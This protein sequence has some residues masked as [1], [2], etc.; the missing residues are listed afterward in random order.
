[1]ID[2][3]TLGEALVSFRTPGPLVGPWRAEAHVAGAEANVAIG[4]ARLGHRSAWVGCVSD[5]DLGT[6]VT[7]TLAAEGVDT[8][9]VRR[10]A[11]APAGA[12]VLVDP[13]DHARRVTY[14]RRGSA[15]SRLTPEDALTALDDEVRWVHL[16]GITPAL[17]ESAHEAWVALAREAKARS[18]R[19]CLDVNFRPALWS[20]EEAAA[21]LASVRGLVDLLVASDDEVD[22]VDDAA[23]PL[24]VVKRGPEGATVVGTEGRVDVPAESV[25][26]VDVIGAG[27]ALCAGLLSGLLDGLDPVA[28]LQ[29]GTWVAGRC[30]SSTGDWEGLPTRGDL[31][32]QA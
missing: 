4:L 28:A 3:L 22:L 24:V 26:V 10:V 25:P 30:V 8:R 29:R 12:M 2:V 27:D 5:D 9:H 17:S 13:S 16:S 11:D 18:V 23:I 1:M 21:T 20:R 15:G 31:P 6:W 32:L 7:G 19:V 14:L